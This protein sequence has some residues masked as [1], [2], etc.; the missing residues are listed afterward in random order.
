MWSGRRDS[1][2]VLLRERRPPFIPNAVVEEFAELLARYAISFV[3]ADRYAAE[4][5][6][7]AF[8][9]HGITLVASER[10]K[11]DI[12]RGLLSLV[13]TAL[14]TCSMTRGWWRSSRPW[15]AARARARP[16]RPSTE[17]A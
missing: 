6:V 7:A 14:W 13:I 2:L 17:R 8:A 9:K 16:D 1:N 5:P 3:T 15:S 11:S 12:Y 10:V 4:W